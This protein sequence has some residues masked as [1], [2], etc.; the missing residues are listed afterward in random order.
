[1]SFTKS[2]RPCA[3]PPPRSGALNL[4]VGLN[5]RY[6]CKS[7]LHV[8]SATVESTATSDA[9]DEIQSSL[10]RRDNESHRLPWVETH[11]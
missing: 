3:L 2:F 8:A 4:A 11:G 7:N 5:P 9:S 10:T 1:L 6:R